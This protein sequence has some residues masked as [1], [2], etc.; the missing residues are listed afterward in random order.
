MKA[1][2]LLALAIFL[3]TAPA[4]DAET[5]KEMTANFV[6]LESE[7]ALQ[8]AQETARSGRRLSVSAQPAGDPRRAANEQRNQPSND[9]A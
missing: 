2:L 1:T 6:V 9:G 7:D 4:P 8:A 5:V 3:V